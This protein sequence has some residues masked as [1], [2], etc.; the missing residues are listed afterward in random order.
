MPSSTIA[1]C[2]WNCCWARASHLAAARA[3]EV[4][5]DGPAAARRRTRPSRCDAALPVSPA[6]PEV[7]AG[8]VFPPGLSGST[9]H[10][11]RL[12]SARVVVGM[13][14]R[15]RTRWRRRTTRSAAFAAAVLGGWRASSWW[16]RPRGRRGG[17]RGRGLRLRRLGRQLRDHR[18]EAQLGGLADERAALARSFTPG[19]ST[20][21]LLPWRVI[22]RLGD[23]EA[24]DAVAD[25]V[26]GDVERSRS[27]TCRPAR[28]P[29]TRRPGGRGRAR[30][31]LP[32]ASVASERPTTSDERDDQEDDVPAHGSVVAR[33]VVGRVLVERSASPADSGARGFAAWAMAP[34]ATVITHAGRDLELDRVVVERA[35]G[36][37]DPADGDD[38]VAHRRG[39]RRAPGGRSPGAAGAAR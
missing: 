26:D 8:R 2:L 11:L 7:V 10:A 19:R 21:M 13:V 33:A 14:V 6:L 30:V 3:G 31:V 37:E 12:S 23:A 32:R 16:S 1:T 35:D 22:S 17:R 36:A 28:A 39:L 15:R 9:T 24:V 34:R 27:C 20:T 29:P 18:P 5:V 4:H 38:L 25:D